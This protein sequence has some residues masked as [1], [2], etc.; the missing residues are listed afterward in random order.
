MDKDPLTENNI[1]KRSIK[2]CQCNNLSYIYIIPNKIDDSI[3]SFFETLGSPAFDFKKTSI[4]KI[5]T[6]EFAI[7]GIRRLK[8]IRLTVKKVD[9]DIVNKFEAVLLDYVKFKRVGGV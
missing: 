3:V 9:S 2:T 6:P 4:L 7:T 5:E 1:K 8:E